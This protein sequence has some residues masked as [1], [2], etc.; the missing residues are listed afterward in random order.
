MKVLIATGG[1][2]GHIYPALTLGHY[3]QKEEEVFLA[4]SFCRM[5]DIVKGHGFPVYEVG[6]VGLAANS[7]KSVLRFAY[8]MLK[9][10]FA[11]K[12]ILRTVKP[13]VVIGFGGYGAF[14]VVLM[15]CLMG[16][17]AVM[18]EQN[19][20]PGRAN[21]LLS[22]M[23]K[24]VAISF[25]ESDK[26]FPSHKT[27]FTGNPGRFKE[28]TIVRAAV[29]EEWHLDKNLFTVLVMGGSQGS[30]KLNIISAEA[31]NLLK[32]FLPVQVIHIAGQ[33][34]EEEV[35]AKYER[36]SIKHCV[37]S[38]LNKIE[39]AYAVADLVVARAGAMTVSEIAYYALPAILIPYPHARAHQRENA[40][41]LSSRGAAVVIDEKDLS[42]PILKKKMMLLRNSPIAE[43]V[44]QRAH[45]D[46]YQP[47]ASSAL[48]SLLQETLY[49]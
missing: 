38:F 21:A 45:Q 13:D 40:Q 35:R 43:E 5:P 47:E 17:P 49:D 42:A 7:L 37:F 15:A 25:T 41:L 2:G 26:Y 23:V 9:S 29:L 32:D 27:S 8:F 10:I 11:S 36:K 6:S 3:L 20:V 12:K 30:E 44:L 1:S 48:A 28:S 39:K 46:L 33:R 31:F 34:D 22:K 18:H 16:I 24:R 19:V 14:P 4:G